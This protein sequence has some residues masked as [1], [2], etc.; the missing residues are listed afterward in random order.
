MEIKMSS[1]SLK[2][3]TLLDFRCFLRLSSRI[4]IDMRSRT[5]VDVAI[6]RSSVSLKEMMLLRSEEFSCEKLT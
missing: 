3:V 5:G 4:F 6:K 2:E 1:E